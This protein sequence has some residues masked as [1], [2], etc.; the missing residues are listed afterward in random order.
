MAGRQSKIGTWLKML[1]VGGGVCIG[2]PAFVF[3]V[4]PSDEELFKRYN[5]ELQKKS[6]NRKFERQKEFDDFVCQLKEFSKSDKPIWIVQEEAARKF[7]EARLQ[8]DA[9]KA[10]EAKARKE[11][12]RKEAGIIG[13]E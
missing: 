13:D 9:K 10:E 2:G 6:L 7:K 12:M 8:E 5:P 1:A 3:W 11:A 4:Q